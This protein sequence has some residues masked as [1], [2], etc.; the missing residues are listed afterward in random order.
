LRTL[1]ADAEEEL[2]AGVQR[3]A[4]EAHGIAFSIEDALLVILRSA[5]T[6]DREPGRDRPAG[7]SLSKGGPRESNRDAHSDNR[8]LGLRRLGGIN[9]I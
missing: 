1:R 9:G 7:K 2:I 4:W 3:H 8:G 5:L 6:Q